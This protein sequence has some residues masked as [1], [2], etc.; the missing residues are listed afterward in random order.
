MILD[1]PEAFA[2]TGHVGTLAMLTSA[3]NS[4]PLHDDWMPAAPSS[5]GAGSQYAQHHHSEAFKENTGV[6]SLEREY[7]S[8]AFFLRNVSTFCLSYDTTCNRI[9]GAIT[10][11]PAQ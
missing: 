11:R 1:T 3:T 8:T 10:N 6:G 4:T 9:G 2:R 5:D 7:R